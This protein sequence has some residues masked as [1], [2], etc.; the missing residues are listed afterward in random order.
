[1]KTLLL[2]RHA[3]A[4]RG[5]PSFDDFNRPL[6]AE[7]Q[8]EAK[9]IGQHLK[10]YGPTPD[11]IF[12]SQARRARETWESL[13]LETAQNRIDYQESLYSAS[14]ASLLNLIREVDAKDPTD[15][16]MI[17]AHNPTIEVMIGGL[18][19]TGSDETALQ[20]A[21]AEVAPAS[22]AVLEFEGSS[23]SRLNPAEGRLVAFLGPA[24]LARG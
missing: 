2:M 19:G 22:L 3:T 11:R 6:S 16:L 5:W 20:R 14:P 8:R 21:R 23:W 12:C 4:D 1:M 13:A 9:G 24:F 18:V 7:G 10:S 15:C 17:I